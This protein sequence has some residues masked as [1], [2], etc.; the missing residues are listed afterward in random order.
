MECKGEF[1][2]GQL[3]YEPLSI[4]AKSELVSW[5]IHSQNNDLLHLPGWQRFA[6]LAQRQK[7]LVQMAN[8]A[9]LQS[10][11][12]RLFTNLVSKYQVIIKRQ[13]SLIWTMGA[14]IGRMQRLQ[15][16]PDWQLWDFPWPCQEGE[17]SAWLQEDSSTL[18]VWCKAWRMTQGEFNCW[19]TPHR[20]P[21]HS[22]VSD[23]W[24]F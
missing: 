7:K 24:Y 15:I 22:K 3:T 9:K 11:R 2:K 4:I 21:N 18:D 13:W 14:A 5:A 20:D 16:I 19:R 1:E 17:T 8:Q 10:F 6:R 12:T 23:W